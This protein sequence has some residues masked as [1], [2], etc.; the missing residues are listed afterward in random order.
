MNALGYS[1]LACLVVGAAGIAGGQLRTHHFCGWVAAEFGFFA[2][3]DLRRHN[4]LWALID[5]A[6]SAYFAWHWWNGGGGND[7]KR[8]LREW[9]RKFQ[10]VRRTAPSAA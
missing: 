5:A 6:G 4:Y 8:R 10:G 3:D 2:V 1:G 7:T 9:G